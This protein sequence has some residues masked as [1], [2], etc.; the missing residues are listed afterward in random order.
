MWTW[1]SDLLRSD[2]LKPS[3]CSC[4]RKHTNDCLKDNYWLSGVSA[5]F[6]SPWLRLKRGWC[7]YF[8]HTGNRRADSSLFNFLLTPVSPHHADSSLCLCQLPSLYTRPE[9]EPRCVEP[10]AGPVEQ[11]VASLRKWA[12]P[13]TDRCQVCSCVRHPVCSLQDTRRQ[14]FQTWTKHLQV[15]LRTAQESA[16]RRSRRS[17]TTD[18]HRNKNSPNLNLESVVFLL[19]TLWKR[20]PEVW[21]FLKL[22]TR[23]QL[24]SSSAL[25]PVVVFSGQRS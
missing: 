16:R 18:A 8:S 19:Q 15:K 2:D 10:E 21:T 13:Y 1:A 3:S 4:Q 12:E 22:V 7:F 24:S 14:M 20:R 25:Q 23:P 5:V 6:L 11:S 9:A 17:R